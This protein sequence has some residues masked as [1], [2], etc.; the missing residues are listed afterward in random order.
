MIQ[1][2]TPPISDGAP[3]YLV[4]YDDTLDSGFAAPCIT[5]SSDLQRDSVVLSCLPMSRLIII[6]GVNSVEVIV[7]IQPRSSF[8]ALALMIDENERKKYNE[9]SKPVGYT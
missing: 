8:L 3:S 2:N 9:S 1:P 7:M 6:P 5:A 4:I